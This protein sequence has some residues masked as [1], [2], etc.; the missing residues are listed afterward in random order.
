M[1]YSWIVVICE[2]D[3]NAAMQ[4]QSDISLLDAE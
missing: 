3:A 2:R 1:C 4:D